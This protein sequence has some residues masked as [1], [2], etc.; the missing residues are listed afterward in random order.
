MSKFHF[1]HLVGYFDNYHQFLDPLFS[2]GINSSMIL[3]KEF[4]A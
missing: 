3:L 1:I 4:L 2:F